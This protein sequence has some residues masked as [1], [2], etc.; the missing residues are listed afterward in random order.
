MRNVS[1]QTG[2][3]NERAGTVRSFTVEQKKKKKQCVRLQ[4]D[5]Q[6]RGLKAG[7]VLCIQNLFQIQFYDRDL[8]TLGNVLKTSGEMLENI[9]KDR[10]RGGE[11]WGSGGC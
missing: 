5:R 7:V 2:K 3:A 4:T 6:C 10:L 1:T 11:R 8:T 9:F